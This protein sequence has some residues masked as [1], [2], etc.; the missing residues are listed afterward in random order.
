MRGKLVSLIQ[1]AVGGCTKHWAEVIAE[2]LMEHGVVVSPEPLISKEYKE[3]LD[4]KMLRAAKEKLESSSFGGH[5][6]PPELGGKTVEFKRWRYTEEAEVE[7][8]EEA[9]A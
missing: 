7:L 6:T 3:Y 1:E 5:V 2:H 8:Q 4:R 9:D